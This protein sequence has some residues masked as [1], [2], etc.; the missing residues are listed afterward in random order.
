M[1]SDAVLA[2]RLLYRFRV[3]CCGGVSLSLSPSA[4]LPALPGGG[5]VS[6]T[7]WPK[8]RRR[9]SPTLGRKLWLVAS[10]SSVYLLQPSVFKAVSIQVFVKVLSFCISSRLSDS[11]RLHVI[12][13]YDVG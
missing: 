13:T 4:R 7:L 3:S 8:A 11:V 1:M 6:G 5:T 2:G 9:R 12:Y 10:A